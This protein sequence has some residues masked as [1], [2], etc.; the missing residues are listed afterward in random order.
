MSVTGMIQGTLTAGRVQQH[1]RRRRRRVSVVTVMMNSGGESTAT[2]TALMTCLLIISTIVVLTA[3]AVNGITVT[4]ET[5]ENMTEGKQV[6]VEFVSSYNARKCGGIYSTTTFR[7]LRECYLAESG[8]AT[9]SL[10]S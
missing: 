10:S 2:F 8:L 6:F 7:F 9:K 5:W 3:S 4:A 1:R